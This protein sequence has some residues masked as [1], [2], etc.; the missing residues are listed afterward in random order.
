MPWSPAKPPSVNPVHL[1]LVQARLAAEGDLPLEPLCKESLSSF[2]HKG[3]VA[4]GH[5]LVGTQ[6]WI[7]WVSRWPRRKGT[8]VLVPMTDFCSSHPM[9]LVLLSFMVCT[10]H[11]GKAVRVLGY[12]TWTL[13]V[14][15]SSFRSSSHVRRCYSLRPVLS[16]CGPQIPLTHLHPILVR[17]CVACYVSIIINSS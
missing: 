2:H 4:Y 1:L 5:C 14:D 7:W 3:S 16:W 13:R 11:A 8:V 15:T 9:M 12:Q 6:L 10:L 17:T